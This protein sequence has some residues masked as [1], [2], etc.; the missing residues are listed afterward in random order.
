MQYLAEEGFKCCLLSLT[1][2][3]TFVCVQRKE[4]LDALRSMSSAAIAEKYKPHSHEKFRQ[5]YPM[6]F[7]DDR[8]LVKNMM[9]LQA[10]G[11]VGSTNQ[12]LTKL[13]ARRISEYTVTAKT[14]E[15]RSTHAAKAAHGPY[16]AWVSQLREIALPVKAE[17]PAPKGA[18]GWEDALA[19]EAAPPLDQPAQATA[20][21]AAAPMP[22]EA[23]AA[24]QQHRDSRD[25][26]PDREAAD[27]DL[28][29]QDQQNGDNI[30]SD[31]ERELLYRRPELYG[32]G[33]NLVKDTLNQGD[34]MFRCVQRWWNQVLLPSL[35]LKYLGFIT[36]SAPAFPASCMLCTFQGSLWVSTNL[37]SLCCRMQAPSR[38]FG[39]LLP[40]CQRCQGKHF[41]PG[42][43]GANQQSPCR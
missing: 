20:P 1:L 24:T 34:D 39:R 10:R 15:Y 16:D 19:S 21:A 4:I 29:D 31:R 7:A 8:R 26:S 36:C 35:S 27:A 37:Q 38:R 42:L 5:Y 11:F 18:P 28:E 32:Q 12:K 17:R 13:P 6:E 9:Q 3:Y 25:P 2:T 43:G 30:L 23:P 14:D 33:S 22:V 40:P 41:H